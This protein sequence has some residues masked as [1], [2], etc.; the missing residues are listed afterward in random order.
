MDAPNRLIFWKHQAK[1]LETLF[2]PMPKKEHYKSLQSRGVAGG[3]LAPGAA[4]A[5]QPLVFEPLAAARESRFGIIT[6]I[7]IIVVIIICINMNIHMY[8]YIYIYMVWVGSGL[9]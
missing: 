1:H 3:L 5:R 9:P 2:G 6:I 7:V 4:L 8:T